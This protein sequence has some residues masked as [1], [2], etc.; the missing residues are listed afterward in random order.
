MLIHQTEELLVT[1][2]KT[3]AVPYDGISVLPRRCYKSILYLTYSFHSLQ[4]CLSFF[5]RFPLSR[6]FPW[7]AIT[8]LSCTVLNIVFSVRHSFNKLY[9]ALMLPYSVTIRPVYFIAFMELKTI[10]NCFYI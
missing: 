5:Q 9:Q 6:I 3:E 2:C 10:G 7:V 4:C 1:V 8:C